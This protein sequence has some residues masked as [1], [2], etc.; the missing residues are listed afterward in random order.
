MTICEICDG[1]GIVPTAIG[2]R[3]CACQVEE[4]ARLRLLR[5]QIPLGFAGCT[6]DNFRPCPHTKEAL[7]MARHYAQE[8]IPGVRDQDLPGLLLSG[9]VG[10]GKTH[11]AAAILRSTIETK[12]I[13]GRF[14]TVPALLDRLRASYDN[15][16]TETPA[17]ILRP[18]MG[19]DLVVID[20]LGASRPTD[21]VFDTIE[22]L[23]GSLYNA[24]RPVI[25][26][27]NYPNLKPGAAP[28][29]N[30]YARAARPE[31][32]YDRIGARMWSR[33]QQMCRPVDMIGPDWRARGSVTSMAGRK[34]E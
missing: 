8:F 5:A 12:G 26:T 1:I 11:L 33:L 25:V 17:Q 27:T 28:A 23:I 29:Q 32:L 34:E 19:A 30:E 16:A 18:I 2:S 13:E 21:W 24:M 20:E 6:L 22:L 9:S 15:G 10:V 7:M 14:V 31:T 3:P 4:Q